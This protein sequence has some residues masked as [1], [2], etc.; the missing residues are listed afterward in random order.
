MLPDVPPGPKWL[1]QIAMVDYD[2]LSDN[3]KGFENDVKELARLLTPEERRRVALCYHGWY[4]TIGGYAYDDAKQ[5]IKQ[6]W[7]GMGRTRK[8]PL[9]QDEVRRQLKL[10]RDLGFRMLAL[11]RRRRCCRTAPRR[12]AIGPQWDLV[13]DRRRKDHRLDGPDTWGTTYAR[14]PAHP[15]VFQWY[16]DYLAALL[17]AFGPVID[18][19]VWDETL[20]IRER[21]S[22]RTPQRAYCDRA[23][24]RLVKTLNAQVRAAD[25]EKVFLT[26]DCI[27]A[28]GSATTVP[29][30]AMVA[31]GNYQDT[32]CSPPAWS[33]GLFPAWRNVSWGCNWDSIS[34]FHN[35]RWGVEHYGVPVA[36]SN[37]WGNDIGPWE[38]KPQDR[39]RILALFRRRLTMGE[40]VRYL[41]MEPNGAGCCRA[42]RYRRRPSA[43][44]NWALAGQGGRATASSVYR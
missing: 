11:L 42:I 16:Q 36:I 40:R 39:E 38:W 28:P 35:T 37:G 17:Q 33:Y 19:F 41:T 30:Y 8:V 27:G 32:G 10:A 29:G 24:L 15:Q 21:A 7:V 25:P 44:V 14:N 13:A 22:P 18:G 3:G 9:S 31:S 20:H 12:P 23:M 43:R 6:Q 26:S 2:Y 34:G 1:R 5:E 4:E